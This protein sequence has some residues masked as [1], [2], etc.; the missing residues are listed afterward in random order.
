MTLCRVWDKRITNRTIKRANLHFWAARRKSAFYGW[1]VSLMT[2]WFHV[3]APKMHLASCVENTLFISFH[4]SYSWSEWKREVL[5]LTNREWTAN[6]D[7][8]FFSVCLSF[9][10]SR[11]TKRSP[12]S[13]F[14]HCFFQRRTNDND[15]SVLLSW[16]YYVRTC[17]ETISWLS[18]ACVNYATLIPRCHNHRQNCP[19]RPKGSFIHLRRDGKQE[20]TVQ[21]PD[22]TDL[23][24]PLASWTSSGPHP[25]RLSSS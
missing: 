14:S 20:V 3:L 19:G 23:G 25:H 11:W 13:S 17:L 5:E 8:L 15:S 4:Y 7:S 2:W 1:C 10:H 12:S 18:T 6:E 22:Q 16:A 9:A 21:H 24:W